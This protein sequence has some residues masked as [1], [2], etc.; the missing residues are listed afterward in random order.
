[1]NQKT[2]Q[3]VLGRAGYGASPITQE[4]IERHLRAIFFAHAFD[5]AEFSS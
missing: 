4:A 2:E 3:T 5:G 1:M